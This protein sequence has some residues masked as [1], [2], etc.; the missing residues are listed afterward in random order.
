MGKWKVMDE[1]GIFARE[2][3][4]GREVGEKKWIVARGKV[5]GE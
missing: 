5:E 4:S 1:E 2:G 3:V